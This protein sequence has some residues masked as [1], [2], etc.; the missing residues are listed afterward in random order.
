MN[1]PSKDIKDYLLDKSDDSNSTLDFT[2]GTNLFISLLPETPVL[3]TAIFDTSGMTPDP[4]NNR[5]PSV[6]ILVRGKVG[7]YETAWAKME[8]IMAE[9]HALANTTINNTLYILI[10]K[11]TEPFHVGN[12]TQGRPIFSCNLRIKRA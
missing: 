11:L 8:A 2:F 3:A 12:D 1:S 4:T 7:G 5:N 9:L 10:W 6:Q